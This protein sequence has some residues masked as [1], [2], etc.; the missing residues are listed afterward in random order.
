MVSP[1]ESEGAPG[2]GKV[3]S[4][5]RPHTRNGFSWQEA[6]WGEALRVSQMWEVLLS[7]GESPGARS[8]ELYEPLRTGTCGQGHTGLCVPA[9]GEG[10]PGETA[11]DGE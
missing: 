3:G 10:L 1:R 2:E 6:H 4:P 8:P 11:I 5:L 7:E 9:T